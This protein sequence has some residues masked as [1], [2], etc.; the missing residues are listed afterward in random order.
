MTTTNFLPAYKKTGGKQD[1]QGNWKDGLAQ[2]HLM[3]ELG[4]FEYEDFEVVSLDEHAL[5]TFE[6]NAVSYTW[7]DSQW[8]EIVRALKKQH[9]KALKRLI[10]IDVICLVRV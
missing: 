6:Y 4:M 5:A 7:S 2:V 3:K 9:P 10:W 1:Q 8:R